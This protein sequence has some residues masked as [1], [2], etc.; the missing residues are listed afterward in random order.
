MTAAEVTD[1]SR[2]EAAEAKLTAHEALKAHEERLSAIKVLSA[3][4]KLP[5]SQHE[6]AAELSSEDFEKFVAT[7]SVSSVKE[8]GVSD[9]GE[10]P[11]Q[12]SDIEKEMCKQ[13]GISEEKFAAQKESK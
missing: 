3:E 9:K 12:L 10:Q 1:I 13:L 8:D 5:P 11:A 7:L 2:A 6:F 4:G